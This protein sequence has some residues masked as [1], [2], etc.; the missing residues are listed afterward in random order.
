MYNQ[1]EV[2]FR[3]YEELNDFL[4]NSKKKSDINYQ[5]SGNSSVKDAIEAIGIPHIE[6]DLIL[7]NGQPVDF[8]HILN[9]NDKISVYPVFE[10]LDITNVKK[11][12]KRP[13]RITRFIMDVHLGKLTKLLRLLGFDSFYRN[14]LDDLEIIAI[15]K[16]ENRI[17]LTRDV[18]L[19]KHNEVTHGYWVRSQNPKEQIKEIL[20]K[21]NLYKKIEP[22]SRCTVCNGEII[23]VEKNEIINLLKP[24]TNKYYNSFYKC[25]TCNKIYWEGSHY[26]KMQKLVENLKKQ[27]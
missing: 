9:N 27:Q 25:P 15:S 7:V 18:G 8:T 12:K 20:K 6:V 1:K 23:V 24:K 10:L 21:F 16:N 14:D 13:L 26:L 5:F 4:P 19:L 17:I 2:I 11:L 3:F 22:F